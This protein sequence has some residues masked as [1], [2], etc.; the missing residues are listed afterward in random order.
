MK[1]NDLELVWVCNVISCHALISSRITLATKQSS[2][3]ACWL[4]SPFG[5]LH[6]QLATLC[7]DSSAHLSPTLCVWCVYVYMYMCEC[8]CLCDVVEFVLLFLLS[9]ALLLTSCRHFSNCPT[10][11]LPHSRLRSSF[12]AFICMHFVK[13]W[14]CCKFSICIWKLTFIPKAV[15]HINNVWFNS[16]LQIAAH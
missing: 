2:P 14:C 1:Q 13:H 6:L 8:A 7:L 11:N 9:L 12:F 16:A 15:N 5:L 10:S 3:F 4:S